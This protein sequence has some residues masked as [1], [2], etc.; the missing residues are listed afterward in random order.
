MALSTEP[1]RLYTTWNT[2]SVTCTWSITG[3]LLDKFWRIKFKYWFSKPKFYDRIS[4]RIAKQRSIPLTTFTFSSPLIHIANYQRVC[5]KYWTAFVQ[6]IFHIIILR[7]VLLYDIKAY[8][9]WIFKW[10]IH[11]Y[12]WDSFDSIIHE[13]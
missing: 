10:F 2:W 6:F 7:H 5:H 8:E 11:L 1:L 4:H 3:I 13:N 12:W 9:L